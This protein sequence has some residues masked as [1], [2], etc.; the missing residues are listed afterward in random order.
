MYWSK[1]TPAPQPFPR[2]NSGGSSDPRLFRVSKGALLP[3][4]EPRRHARP[5][6]ATLLSPHDTRSSSQRR[7]GQ[8]LISSPL[9]SILPPRFPQSVTQ[10][11]PR[12]TDHTD[13]AQ[14][15]SFHILANSFA[16]RK[17]LS[18]VF[19]IKS[20]LFAQN[21]RGGVYPLP[22]KA[23]RRPGSYPAYL[24]AG[25]RQLSTVSPNTRSGCIGMAR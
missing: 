17:T 25:D 19:S 6:P 7:T 4:P 5:S 1:S 23:L 15:L 9:Y 8:L 13:L 18:S 20:E 16:P 12:L 11:G 22:S 3:W 24:L 10:H 21:T 14:L 2:R